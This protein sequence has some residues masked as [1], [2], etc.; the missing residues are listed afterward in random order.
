MKEKKKK[1][2]V[3]KIFG[4]L[5]VILLALVLAFGAY[6]AYVFIDYH[7]IDDNQTLTVRSG[8]DGSQTIRTGETYSAVTYNIGFAAYTPDFSFFMDGGTQ[9]RANSEQSVN[10]TMR[11]ICG[12]LKDEDADF[13][14]IE[15]VD[16]D[17]TR[18]H[19]VNERVILE[20][21][22]ADY[23]SVYAINYDSP[24]LF[25][26]FLSP[27]G[28]SLAGML[29]ASRF[30][31]TGSVRRSLPV[32]ESVMKI[33]DLDRCYSVTR[34]PVEGGHEF[35]LYTAHLSAYTSDGSIADEQLRMLTRD[36]Q[37]EYEKGNY[38]VCG[39]D[40]NKDLLGDSSAY[41]GV[42][43][44]ENTWAQP[45]DPRILDEAGIELAAPLDEADPVPSCRNADAPYHDGQFVLVVDGF[46][47]SKN[48]R[49]DACRV[50]DTGFAYSDHN[51]V[52]L[53]FT[54]LENEEM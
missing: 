7:R 15:E 51:P 21:A 24:Y 18:S 43:G 37:A 45:I 38:V 54:L 27:H 1:S 28:K 42:S 12:I 9:S 46:L 25:Y 40:F 22:L 32:E 49:A 13:Y 44:G 52:R 19:H 4:T 26:P 11:G 5:G 3:K 6:A 17:A 29:T 50:I 47:V 39:G 41:F 33:V 36:M 23:D 53:E 34:F 14:L 10:E 2:A 48:V 16:E 31:M 30:S 35:V 8:A 20:D